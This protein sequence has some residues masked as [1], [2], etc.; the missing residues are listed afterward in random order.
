M[1]RHNAVPEHGASIV[2]DVGDVGLESFHGVRALGALDNDLAHVPDVHYGKTA[3][4]S[5][6]I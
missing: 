4:L 1:E 3:T 2:V 6:K 5:S